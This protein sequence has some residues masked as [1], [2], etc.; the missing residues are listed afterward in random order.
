MI[1]SPQMLE[2]VAESDGIAAMPAVRDKV[3]AR[4]FRG[5]GRGG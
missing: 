4:A 2:R 3:R 5:A 1:P